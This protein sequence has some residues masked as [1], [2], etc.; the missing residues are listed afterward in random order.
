MVFAFRHVLIGQVA[1]DDVPAEIPGFVYVVVAAVAMV[2]A[3]YLLHARRN[4]GSRDRAIR[5]LAATRGWRYAA[6]DPV[7]IGDLR[8]RSFA[9]AKHALVTN[10]LTSE[11]G[12]GPVRAFDYSLLFERASSEGD[13]L[14]S[15]GEDLFGFEP[16]GPPRVKKSYTRRRTGA[17]VHIDAFLPALTVS[18][19]TFISRA[20]ETVGVSDL[21]FESVEFNRKWDVRC[22]DERFAWLFCDASMIDTILELGDGVTVET[23]GNYILFT[24]DLVGDAEALLRFLEHVTRVPAHLNPLVREEYP[25]VAAMESRVMIDEWSQRPDGRRG[26]Y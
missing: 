22:V 13:G 25:T 3:A 15:G 24:R 2:V 12:K 9:G 20:F 10:V 5:H 21:D 11:Q 6:S 8:F 7:G 4:A 23:F 14:W 26:V 16:T 19:A 1:S 18:P 17:V